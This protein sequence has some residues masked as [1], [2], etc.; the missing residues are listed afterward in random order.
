[1]PTR[2]E[3]LLQYAAAVKKNT[4]TGRKNSKGRT[5]YQGPRGGLFVKAGDRKVYKVK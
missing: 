3:L 1:M 5:I 4:N 2:R